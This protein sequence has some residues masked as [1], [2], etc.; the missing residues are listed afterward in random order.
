[1]SIVQV[2]SATSSLLLACAAIG[3]CAESTPP[4]SRMPDA[5]AGVDAGP[6]ADAG[7]ATDAGPGGGGPDSGSTLDAGDPTMTP[8]YL[9]CDRVYDHELAY[10]ATTGDVHEVTLMHRD[11]TSLPASEG[12]ASCGGGCTENVTRLED[13]AT[14]SGV[15]TFMQ[16][17]NVQV[18]TESDSGVGSFTLTVDGMV[19]VPATDMHGSGTA[20]FNNFPI[21]AW[22]VP[23]AGDHAFTVRASGGFVDVR[24]VT[25][26]CRSSTSGGP[27]AVDLKVNGSDG[28]IMLGAPA[29]YTLSWTTMDASTCEAIGAW[30]GGRATMGDEAMSDVPVG[31]YVYTLSCSNAGGTAVDTV[32]VQVSMGP[33]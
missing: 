5:S 12:G 22:P 10:F 9:R 1:M 4:T 13:G 16:T 6:R 18:A 20:G 33:G 11:G 2:A 15:F 30:M 8:R 29:R 25:P 32:T 19:V 14:L 28:M 21:P 24:A 17:F 23:D 26:S 27:P 3:G 7:P 31:T